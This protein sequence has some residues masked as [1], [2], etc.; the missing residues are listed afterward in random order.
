MS[1]Q[2]PENMLNAIKSQ[3]ST[4]SDVSVADL[5]ITKMA[6]L[7]NHCYCVSIKNAKPEQE[8]NQIL[9]RVFAQEL[10]DRRIEQRIFAA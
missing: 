2:E 9:F 10:T 4:W 8:P 6:G 5:S 1:L 3:L 7:S